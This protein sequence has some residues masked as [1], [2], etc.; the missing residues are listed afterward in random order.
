MALSLL[1]QNARGG[2]VLDLVFAALF[3]FLA[4]FVLDL[5]GVNLVEI[6]SGAGRFFGL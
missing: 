2:I 4:A 6:L 3:L 5:L 1:H